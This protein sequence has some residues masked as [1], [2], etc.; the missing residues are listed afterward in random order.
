METNLTRRPGWEA[1]LN[2]VIV[3]HMRAPFAWGQTDC[4]TFTAAAIEALSGVDIIAPF[5]GYTSYAGGLKRARAAGLDGLEAVFAAR[6]RAVPLAELNRGDAVVIEEA[7]EPVMG[8]FG[9]PEAYVMAS[10]GLGTVGLD[11]VL[12]GYA[13]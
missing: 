7:G 5:R 6:L 11:R 1:R 9:A 12:R 10:T 3:G 8:V 13:V 2:A 4:A